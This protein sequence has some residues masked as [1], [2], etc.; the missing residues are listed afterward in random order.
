[1]SLASF[2]VSISLTRDLATHAAHMA[3][4][5][6]GQPWALRVGAEL[7]AIRYRPGAERSL[8]KIEDRVPTWEDQKT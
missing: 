5:Q 6:S 2:L 8:E 4:T 7:R 1:M 3:G